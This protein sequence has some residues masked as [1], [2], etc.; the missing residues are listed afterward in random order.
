MGEG[1][2]LLPGSYV[3]HWCDKVLNQYNYEITSGCS[4]WSVIPI[5]NGTL[6]TDVLN[7]V[8]VLYICPSGIISLSE[9]DLVLS[10]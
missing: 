1:K 3:I 9:T 7:M 10:W 5:Y 6:L 2:A 8:P 4:S